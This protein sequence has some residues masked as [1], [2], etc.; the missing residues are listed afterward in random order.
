MKKTAFRVFILLFTAFSTFSA[1]AAVMSLQQQANNTL[2]E[3]IK[4]I[5][6][7]IAAIF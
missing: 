6:L 4:S 3:K 1:S 2:W 7:A 5:G